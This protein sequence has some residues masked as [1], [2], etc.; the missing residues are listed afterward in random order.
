MKKMLLVASVAII[1]LTG[2][3]SSEGVRADDPIFAGVDKNVTEEVLASS[4]VK[5]R[6]QGDD[7]ATQKIRLQGIALNF[8]L[9]RQA[10]A[11]YRGWVTTGAV[12]SLPRAATLQHPIETAYTQYQRDRKSFGYDLDSGDVEVLRSHLMNETGCGAWIPA[13]PDDQ[14]GPTI[15]DA[16]RGS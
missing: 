14:R 15:A 2:C 8:V 3:A 4:A 16:V 10:Y 9:C 7:E 1:A 5:D 6:T 11:A 12:P 13:K